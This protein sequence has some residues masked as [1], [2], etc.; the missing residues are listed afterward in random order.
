MTSIEELSRQ[1]ERFPGIGPRQARRFVYHLLTEDPQAL[2]LLAMAIADI[3]TKVIECPHCFRYFASSNRATLCGICENGARNH[4]LLIVVERDSDIMPIE[5]SGTYDGYYFVLGG[6]VP[7]LDPEE[8][9]K[10]RGGA[11]RGITEMRADGGLKEVILAFSVNPDGEN[12]ARYV[13]TLLKDPGE[14]H[15]IKISILGRGLSTGSE[16]EYA[17]P[18]TIK[19]A[20]K[21]RT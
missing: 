2:Q 15:G 1:F 10:L 19:N 9:I 7:L 11:L 21:N 4:E 14:K 20:L 3:Q 16:L 17:D 5:Y 6:T 18:E 12:T 8:N 13:T